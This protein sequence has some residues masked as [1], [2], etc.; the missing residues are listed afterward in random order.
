LTNGGPCAVHRRALAQRRG[1]AARRGYGPAHHAWRERILGLDPLCRGC[2]R[3]PSTH[4]EHV[5][6]WQQ[7]GEQFSEANG[8]GCCASCANYKSQREQHDPTF[9]ARLRAAGAALPPEPIV[10]LVTGAPSTRV[11]PAPNGWRYLKDFGG[12]Q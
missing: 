3:V 10:D 11:P 7:G 5:E 1:S 9:G 4:A 6:P 2:E 8:Q 12:D